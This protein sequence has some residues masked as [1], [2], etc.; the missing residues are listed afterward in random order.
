[1]KLM[2]WLLDQGR[3]ALLQLCQQQELLL[4]LLL[5]KGLDVLVET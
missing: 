4:K 2:F 1:M 5:L 3:A